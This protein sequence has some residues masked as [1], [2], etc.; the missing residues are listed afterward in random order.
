MSSYGFLRWADQLIWARANDFLPKFETGGALFY[1]HPKY[2]GWLLPLQWRHNGH[3]CVSNHQPRDYLL[4]C[5]FRLRS[6][7]TPKL[8]VTGLCAGTSPGPVN[9]P[10]TWPVARK[11]FPFDDVIMRVKLCCRGMCLCL[12]FANIIP[13]ISLKLRVNDQTE[14]PQSV[15]D[16]NIR[17]ATTVGEISWNILKWCLVSENAL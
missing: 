4:N 14:F 13:Y 10:H 3:D 8:R 17:S 11:M 9:S 6:K 7:K 5:L 1:S 12:S 16:N 15:T 2:S